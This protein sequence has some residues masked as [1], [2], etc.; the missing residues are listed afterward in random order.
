MEVLRTA[1]LEMLRRKKGKRFT[2]AEVVKQLYPED[3]HHFLPEIN[4]E[5]RILSDEG[6][7][8]IEEVTPGNPSTMED[9]LQ[10][11]KISPPNKLK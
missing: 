5:V 3:W 1:I 6:I 7:L 2:S 8:R 10:T 9:G 11:L 4:E